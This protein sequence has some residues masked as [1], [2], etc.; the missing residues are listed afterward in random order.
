LLALLEWSDLM[1]IEESLELDAV[2]ELLEQWSTMDTSSRPHRDFRQRQ[3]EC[4]RIAHVLGLPLPS[5]ACQ[6]ADGERRDN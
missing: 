1:T 6:Q 5:D 3:A 2:A 4:E